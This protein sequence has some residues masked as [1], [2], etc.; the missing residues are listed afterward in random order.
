MLNSI[1]TLSTAVTISAPVAPS[2]PTPQEP[3]EN[4]NPS[5]SDG[6]NNSNTPAPVVNLE[7]S[8]TNE[9]MYTTRRVNIRQGYGTNSN[10]IQTLA[11]GT[12]VTRTGVSKGNVD[13]YS[14]SRVSYNGVTGYIITG[15]LTY[16]A[17]SQEEPEEE[18]P[19][20][21]TNEENPE[22]NNEQNNE[23]EVPDDVLTKL[24]EELGTIPEVGLNIMPF[25]FLGCTVSCL[26]L[27]Y[28]V[29]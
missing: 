27:R 7:F 13:G 9:K 11:E 12:E 20:E 17:P 25:L 29:K 15:G 4:Q 24:S 19:E 16:D 23:N 22:E 5:S 8:D 10:I 28:E 26:T 2:E 21:P 18:Q 1:Q 14:W 6:N 3:S